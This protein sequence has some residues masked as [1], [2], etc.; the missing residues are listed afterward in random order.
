MEQKK[1]ASYLEIARKALKEH[2]PPE[3]AIEFPEAIPG[4][5]PW[6]HEALALIQTTIDRIGNEYPPA[7][8]IE[9]S[10]ISLD[11]VDWIR[12]QDKVD[13]AF[14]DQNPVDLESTLQAYEE[15]ARS[16]FRRIWAEHQPSPDHGAMAQ[17][18]A[19]GRDEQSD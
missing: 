8:I 17:E 16:L 9:K 19:P 14:H 7:R 13:A 12:L 5:S 18:I 1:M 10:G 3:Q 6:Q 11:S 4:L 2:K 15:T